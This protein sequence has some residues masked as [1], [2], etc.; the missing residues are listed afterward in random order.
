MP[1]RLGTL[2][3]V[4][5]FSLG[6]SLTACNVPV[7]RYAIEH[8]HPSPYIVCAVLPGEPTAEQSRELKLLA[9]AVD[10]S[11]NIQ[12]YAR[13]ADNALQ[14]T[15]P[16]PPPPPDIEKLIQQKHFAGP[17]LVVLSPRD[18]G[19]RMPYGDGPIP[20]AVLDALPCKSQVVYSTPLVPGVAS[21]ILHS[22]VRD[23][24]AEDF[25]N[26]AS[27]V[28]LLLGE[29]DK[30]KDDG[31][32]ASLTS[33][34]SA[35]KESANAELKRLAGPPLPPG[36]PRPPNSALTVS[37]P[38]LRVPKDTTEERVLVS[39]LGGLFAGESGGRLKLPVV[40]PV[41]GR[42][43]A[44][45]PVPGADVSPG[46]IQH[47]VAFL[48]GACSC[49]IKGQNPGADLL[50]S[51]NWMKAVGPGGITP[52]G[53]RRMTG[54]GDIAGAPL[55]VVNSE[56]PKP[57]PFASPVGTASP[58]AISQP[59]NARTVVAVPSPAPSRAFHPSLTLLAM[60]GSGVVVILLAAASV[61]VLRNK[62]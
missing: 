33:L 18:T 23:A 62:K 21:T 54:P 52:R 2:A 48:T 41:F 58:K 15:L 16:A 6:S 42:G 55:A 20:T 61:V 53:P 22:P 17:A 7:F 35:T 4:G 60:A 9:D 24:M 38:I 11:A 51:A 36:F 49:E 31:L 27:A 19:R 37:F 25:E 59:A 10:G 12:L 50:I 3:I 45:P 32:E 57:A 40:I 14:T 47:L 8:W 30:A 43:R 26:G 28:L 39:M 46:S 13:W 56:S 44:L 34:L 1:K 5:L 29:G